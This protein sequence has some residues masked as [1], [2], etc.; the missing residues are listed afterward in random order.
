MHINYNHFFGIVYAQMNLHLR[1]LG[2]SCFWS[3]RPMGIIQSHRIGNKKEI[4]QY[5]VLKKYKAMET[6][7]LLV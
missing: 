2:K 7:T 5:Q 6:H 3:I 1:H 4:R